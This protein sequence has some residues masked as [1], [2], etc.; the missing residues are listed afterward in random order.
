ML[1]YNMVANFPL[2]YPKGGRER[3]SIGR[4]EEKRY[5]KGDRE[6]HTEAETHRGLV[7]DF[8]ISL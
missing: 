3:R 6:S 5:R 8:M 7:L 4:K 1:S 2:N